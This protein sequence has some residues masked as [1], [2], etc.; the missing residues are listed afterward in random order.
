[1]QC[2][3]LAFVKNQM[4]NVFCSVVVQQKDI[5][6]YY[7]SSWWSI[8]LTGRPALVGNTSLHHFEKWVTA[9]GEACCRAVAAV[10]KVKPGAWELS[11]L[12]FKQEILEMAKFCMDLFIH[13]TLLLI[14]CLQDSSNLLHVYGGEFRRSRTVFP[15]FFCKD[16]DLYLVVLA[17]TCGPVL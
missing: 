5:H 10:V 6:S 13:A 14:R 8:K 12:V 11:P 15:G 4:E 17:H 9:S 3:L 16:S 1:M 7:H 2:H